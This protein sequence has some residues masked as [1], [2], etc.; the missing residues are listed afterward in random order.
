[1]SAQ[2]CR[3]PNCRPLQ[4]AG[5]AKPQPRCLAVND[6]FT[7][8]SITADQKSHVRSVQPHVMQDGMLPQ[9]MTNEKQRR[10]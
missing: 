2:L 1:M 7:R 3:S 4:I 9:A 10:S 6:A 5:Y 8:Q